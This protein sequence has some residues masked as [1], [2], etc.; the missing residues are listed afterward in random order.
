MARA[1]INRSAPGQRILSMILLVGMISLFMW[2][3]KYGAKLLYRN[4][5]PQEYSELVEKYSAENGL[6]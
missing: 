5:Y 1:K 2:G 4:F 6:D 3:L